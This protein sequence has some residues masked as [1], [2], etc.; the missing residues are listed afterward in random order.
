MKKIMLFTCCAAIGLLFPAWQM[1]A[2][3]KN[4]TEKKVETDSGLVGSRWILVYDNPK[5]GKRK[6]DLH[7]AEGGKLVNKSPRETSRENDTWEMSG[8]KVILKFN[9]GFA[10]YT[11]ELIDSHHME[12]TATSA[13][14][15]KWKWKAERIATQESKPKE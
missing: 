9:N 7:F 11:G 2:A 8:D 4:P 13:T 14:G 12:G 5:F 15:G 10:I 3:E 6:H 1:S